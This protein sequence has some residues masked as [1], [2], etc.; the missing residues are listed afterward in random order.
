MAEKTDRRVRKT[1][2]Q[3]RLG[4]ARLMKKKSIKEI[5][6]KELVNEVDINRSTFYLH[7]TDIYDLLYSIEEELTKEIQDTIQ[8]HP[9]K[10]FNEDTL[11]FIEEI[12]R[13]LAENRDICNAL[14]GENGDIAFIHRME[15]LI[16]QHSLNVLKKT[17]PNNTEILQYPYSFCLTGC[18][19][20]IK[21]WLNSD[22][23][24]SPQEMAEIAFR[25]IINAVKAFAPQRKESFQQN[26]L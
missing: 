7:Y 25:L 9:V 6:V 20:L 23:G 8:A 4:L 26:F 11:P 14:F 18:V 19:G 22:A 5:T 13:I 21:A 15:D 10:P 24:E 12:F 2:A 17:F 16:S 3:L 1:K